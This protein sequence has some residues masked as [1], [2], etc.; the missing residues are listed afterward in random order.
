MDLGVINKKAVYGRDR[1]VVRDLKIFS[2][3]VVYFLMIY[4]EILVVFVMYIGDF[5]EFLA[6]FLCSPCR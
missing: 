4:I 5:F 6:R 2:I 1:V 3:V